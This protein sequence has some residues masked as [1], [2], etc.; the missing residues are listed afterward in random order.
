M[1]NFLRAISNNFQSKADACLSAVFHLEALAELALEP[2]QEGHV[3]TGQEKD[4]D[5]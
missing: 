4:I 5:I 3:V 1:K 2:L